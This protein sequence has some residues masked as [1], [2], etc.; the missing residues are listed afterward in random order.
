MKI[1]IFTNNYLPNPYG[2][3]GSIESFRKELEK[4]GH[5]VFI[6][7]PRW[8][9][10]SDDNERVFRYPA[11]D[12]NIKFRFPLA[13]PYSWKINKIIKNL[14]LDI[15]HSQHP[16]LLGTAAKK[17]ARKKSASRRIPLVFTWHTLY[18]QYTNF[19][20]FLPKKWAA[21]WI[22][23]K[24]VQYANQC[25]QIIVPTE[26]VKKII[27]N[28]GV[29]NKNIVAIPTGVEE[30]FYQNSDRN[31]IRQKYGIKNDE[32]L[33]LLVSRL[34]EEKNVEFL[35]DAVSGILKN[36]KVHPVKSPQNGVASGEFNRVKFLVAGDGY[37]MPKLKKFCVYNNIA[38]K[39]IFAGAVDKKEIK[40]YYAAGD[41]F[42]YASKSETQGMIISE[43]MYC[44][45]PIVAVRATGIEDLV[46]NEKNGFLVAENKEIFSD[47]V[48][49]I[50]ANETLRRQFSEAS[51]KIAREKYT[52][53]VCG[54]KMLEIYNKL[55]IKNS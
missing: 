18:D 30:E 19:V 2:V 20:P 8:K 17:W 13:I 3:T 47:K 22:I 29:V 12:I 5:E 52:S 39:V 1:G 7:A 15:I 16:N 53:A 44:G 34:T 32:I 23:K 45:L 36:D 4:I 14:D 24:A 31:L 50:I 9:G 28:W 37:L 27:Q 42:V 41:I 33:L 54:E 10:Y 21:R 43:A 48:Q 38:K 51:K 35:L 25:D 49:K 6:F 40:N 46:E 11:L 26:S 55:I